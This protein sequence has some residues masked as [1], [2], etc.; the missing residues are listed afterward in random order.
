MSEL[1]KEKSTQSMIAMA[2]LRTLSFLGLFFM[3]ALILSNLQQVSAA[4]TIH[5][6]G[7][8][9]DP[10]LGEGFDVWA[11]V[12]D[13]AIMN[14]DDP[15]VKNVTVQ[16][17]GPNMTYYGLMTH[18]GTFYIGSVP[19][20]PNDGQFRVRILSFDLADDQRASAF[21]YI[22]YEE[23]PAPDL[24]PTLTMPMVVGS[25]VVFMVVVIGL[26]VYYDR[27][28]SSV[29]RLESQPQLDSE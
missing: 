9:G 6:W 8:E 5:A 16:V 10:L 7:I 24:D 29:G 1:I 20:F 3:T 28:K 14:D 11:N 26:A 22:D 27:K 17:L 2:R 13:D 4:P 18:N 23:N 21:I 15:G 19:T 25:S 12:S